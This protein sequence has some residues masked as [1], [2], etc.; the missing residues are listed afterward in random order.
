M[1]GEIRTDIRLRYVMNHFI[2]LFAVASKSKR[3]NASSPR[4][5]MS[6]QRFPLPTWPL[7]ARRTIKY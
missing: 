6:A 4:R 3:R 7:E 2:N 5:A 1:N